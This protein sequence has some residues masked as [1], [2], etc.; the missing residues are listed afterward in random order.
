MKNGKNISEQLER[1]DAHPYGARPFERKDYINKF[2]ILTNNI[3]SRQESLR[4]IKV[5]QN[6]KKLRNGQLNKLNIEV[7][8]KYLK[9]NNKKG[10]F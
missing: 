3:I 6:L 1:A 5:V 8:K 9:T 2:K 4:F 10:I 7:D